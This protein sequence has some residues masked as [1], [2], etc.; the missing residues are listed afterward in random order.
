MLHICI[1]VCL[2]SVDTFKLTRVFQKIKK[3]TGKSLNYFKYKH[4][5]ISLVSILVFEAFDNILKLFCLIAV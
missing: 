2:G 5:V 1:E 3:M 4:I